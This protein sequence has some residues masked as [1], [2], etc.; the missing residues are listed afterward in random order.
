M[1]FHVYFLDYSKYA[2]QAVLDMLASLAFQ[3]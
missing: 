3:I 1:T 2:Y